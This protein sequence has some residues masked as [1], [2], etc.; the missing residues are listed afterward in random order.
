MDALAAEYVA[1]IAE[2]VAY[3]VAAGYAQIISWEELCLLRPASLKVSSS[4]GSPE[5]SK[6][7]NDPGLVVCSPPRVRTK[8]RKRSCNDKVILQAL[9]NK[10]TV[11]MA[12]EE[13]VKELGN[14][15]PCILDYM[16]QVPPKERIHFS[17]MDLANGYWWMVVEPDS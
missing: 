3:Q 11:R 15:L 17:K 8:G 1:S 12:P 9:V 2:D 16:A 7:M 6:G 4:R 10:T 5:E 14:V 13:P